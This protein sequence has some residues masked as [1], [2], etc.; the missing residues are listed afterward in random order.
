MCPVQGAQHAQN[1]FQA[2]KNTLEQPGQ[3]PCP[4][5]NKLALDQWANG[6]HA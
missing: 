3:G 1:V 2:E 4:P 6:L 5:G